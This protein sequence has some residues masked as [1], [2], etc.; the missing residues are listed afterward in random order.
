MDN[1]WKRD[2]QINPQAVDGYRQICSVVYQA[3]MRADLT[4]AE[5]KVVLAIIDQTWG[6]KKTSSSIPIPKLIELTG[7]EDRTLHR[8][9]KKLKQKRVICYQ[10]SE[11]KGY[12][13]AP[14]NEFLFNKHFD[15]WKV[16]G[17][18]LGQPSS[19]VEGCHPGSL[20]GVI[21]GHRGVSSG[22]PLINIKK[23]L[24][25]VLKKTTLLDC[26]EMKLSLLLLSLIRN[27]KPDFKEPDLQKWSSVISRM[28]AED[29]RKP[30]TIEDVIRWC[31]GDDYWKVIILST[32]RL[33]KHFDELE[34]KMLA[35]RT[36][37][38]DDPF[39]R[40]ARAI[41]KK[42]EPA[43]VKCEYCQEVYHVKDDHQ[44]GDSGRFFSK[45]G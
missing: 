42:T 27:T 26:V 22:S 23:D 31:Q 40:R 17:C 5:L 34:M 28:I 32:K 11:I 30:E 10:S 18:H 7:L 15:T 21:Q 16:E 20:R 35:Q 19:K 14:L 43:M 2:S 25:K 6:Y 12:H 39:E 9:I 45:D 13:N 4:G 29:R 33:R 1:P 8:V 37:D 24:K 38:D 36:K 3:L 41:F 44:Y